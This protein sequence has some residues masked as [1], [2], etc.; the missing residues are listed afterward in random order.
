MPGNFS[1]QI[2]DFAHRH[3][4]KSFEKKYPKYWDVTLRAI[5]AELERIDMLLE[6]D[7]AETI[8]DVEGV[9]IIKTKFKVAGTKESAKTSG[10]RCIV[11][12]I[13]DKQLVHVLLVYTK[14]DLGEGNE[15]AKWKKLVKDNYP[16]YARLT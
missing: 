13:P 12:W 1:V 4:I 15:T 3:F 6:R 5:T 14:T 7:I 16:E 10:N 11:A 8:C 9:K 2:G